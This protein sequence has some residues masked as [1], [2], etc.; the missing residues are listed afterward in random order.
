MIAALIMAVFVAALF[1]G[2]PAHVPSPLIGKPIPDFTL[3]R[4]VAETGAIEGMVSARDMAQ[5]TPL[6]LNVWASW[7]A[8][9]RDEHPHLM[10]LAANGVP[11]IGLNY[12]DSNQ[13]ARRFLRGLGNPFRAIGVDDKGQVALRL[14]VYGVPESFIIGG[15]GRVLA[16]LVGPLD[17]A[18][19][20]AEITPLLE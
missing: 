11:I 18:R 14:G 6:I 15:D 10:Q 7:C 8:P 13:A 16:R 12:K 20:A 5:G 3:P 17:A 2:N 1:G 4:L 19:I 9:C